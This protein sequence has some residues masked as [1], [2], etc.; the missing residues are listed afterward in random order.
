MQRIAAIAT[1]CCSPPESP[2]G[3][4]S[5]RSPMPR[6][7]SVASICSSMA[8][9]ATP[10]FSSPK[11]SSSRTVSFDPESW[12]DGVEKTMPTSPRRSRTG[13]REAARPP[14]ETTR[15]ASP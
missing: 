10:R 14:I 6:A 11:A 3:R 13:V 12:F 7:A 1:R 8:L 4:R 5:A 15:P 9:R 2:V